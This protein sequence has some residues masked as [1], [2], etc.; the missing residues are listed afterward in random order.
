MAVYFFN[1]IS[2]YNSD[3]AILQKRYLSLDPLK[4]EKLTVSSNTFFTVIG[5]FLSLAEVSVQIPG[6]NWVWPWEEKGVSRTNV[7]S[8]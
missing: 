6:A 1:Q 3:S 5:A 4:R 2:P 7:A 8:S